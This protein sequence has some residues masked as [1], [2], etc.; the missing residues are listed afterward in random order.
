[1]NLDLS[2]H[3]TKLLTEPLVRHA[4][5]IFA[6]TRTHREAI[7]TQ[8]PAQ[9]VQRTF[10]AGR[11][12]GRHLRSDRRPSRALFRSCAAQLLRGD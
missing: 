4:D 3:E 12:R 8:W 5:L 1:M 6:M 7:V 9:A 10:F 2:D 11:R